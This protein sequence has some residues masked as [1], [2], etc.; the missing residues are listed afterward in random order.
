VKRLAFLISAVVLAAPSASCARGPAEPAT[1]DLSSRED[2]RWCRMAIADARTAGQIAAP[3]EEPLFFDDIGCLAEYLASRGT[4]AAGAV[5]Y[6]ADHRTGA[7][8]PAAKAIYTRGVAFETPMASH[9]MA[10]ESAASRDADPAATDGAP[11]PVADLY[12]PG[13][14]PG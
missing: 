2:C 8:V 4:H 3:L 1:L 6:V 11:V 10:H 7:W 9:L 14:P 12:G 5:A 13:G